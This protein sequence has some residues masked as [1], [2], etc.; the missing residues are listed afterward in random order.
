VLLTLQNLKIFRRRLSSL[1][2]L[3]IILILV[4][5][6]AVAIWINDYQKQTALT[7]FNQKQTEK[8]AL[9]AS[10]LTDL[11]QV[12]QQR[13]V[14]MSAADAEDPVAYGWTDASNACVFSTIPSAPT[15]EACIPVSFGTINSLRQAEKQGI[16]DIAVMQPNTPQAHILLAKKLDDNAGYLVVTLQTTELENKLRERYLTIGSGNLALQQGAQNWLTL[17]EQGE[18]KFQQ[19]SRIYTQALPGAYW[20][21]AF[22]PADRVPKSAAWPA[23]AMLSII[24]FV[25]SWLVINRFSTLRPKKHAQIG[26]RPRPVEYVE[27][28]VNIDN[29]PTPAVIRVAAPKISKTEAVDRV[30]PVDIKPVIFKAYDIRGIVGTQ[31]SEP[32]M[33]VLGLAIGTEAQHQEQTRIIVGRDGRLSSESFSDALIEGIL[34]S[35]CDV[36]DIGAV[37]T[38]LV[39]FASQHMQ[40][41]CGVVVTGSHNPQGY[42]GLKIVI[43]D[44]TLSGDAIQGIYHRIQNS[45]LYDGEG[46]LRQ[47]DIIDSYIEKVKQV[48]TLSRPLKVGVDCGNGI[49]GRVVPKL[50][51]ALGCD[52]HELYCNVDGHFPNHHPNPA[53]PQNMQD[54]SKLVRDKHLDIGLAF[55]GDG[56]RLGVVNGEGEIIWPDRLLM[57]FASDILKRHKGSTIIYD[58]KSSGL[59]EQVITKAGGK[60]MMC[61]SGHSLIRAEMLKH[62]AKLAGELSG[63]IFFAD[64]WYGFDDALF[65]A[66][67]LLALIADDP[68]RRGATEIFAAQPQSFNTPEIL[69]DLDTAECRRFMTQFIKNAQFDDADVITIDGVRVNFGKGWGLVRASNTVPG[70]TLRF[71]AETEEDLEQIK[72]QFI[73]QMLQVKPNLSL[74]F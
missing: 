74:N 24:I 44:K 11:L 37:P 8:L 70:L 51:T 66:G 34:A 61:P 33:R 16:A 5:G 36:T 2:I 9:A 29:T 43:N 42:N 22:W 46:Q 17:L 59:L 56:D 32:I 47:A 67:R 18:S 19:S 20:R 62:E 28:E 26:A 13:F 48:I 69:I 3:L 63:H 6:L 7:A 35:G 23:L 45:R 71:E 39:Y 25:L 73:Q 55:D 27:N 38:P 21:L 60:A 15:S 49:A 10:G 64:N 4:S 12:W 31:L 40:T 57:L 72:Q 68:Q 65:A 30:R 52:V 58:V 50:L 53:N 1:A 41:H 14:G 54:I